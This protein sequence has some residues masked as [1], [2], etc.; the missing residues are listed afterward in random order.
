MLSREDRLV[1]G[2]REGKGVHAEQLGVEEK[3]PW[4][5]DGR[6]LEWSRICQPRIVALVHA[7]ATVGLVKRVLWD[8]TG[9][10]YKE[11]GMEQ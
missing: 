6:S 4:M 7:S 10:G 9:T 11:P 5:G 1:G 2:G 8:E 3:H